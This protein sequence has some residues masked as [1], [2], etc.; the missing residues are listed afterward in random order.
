MDLGLFERAGKLYQQVLETQPLDLEAQKGRFL[1]LFYAGS[2]LDSLKFVRKRVASGT[3]KPSLLL[4]I[5]DDAIS[6]MPVEKRHQLL[7]ELLTDAIKGSREAQEDYLLSL[8][9]FKHYKEAI[10]WAEVNWRGP[11]DMPAYL[12]SMVA[13]AYFK[14][15]KVDKAKEYFL[16]ALDKNPASLRSQMG[17]AY[18]MAAEGN[19]HKALQLLDKLM[20]K[21][22]E[23]LEVRFAR[24]YAH[25]RLGQFL[26]AAY[27]YEQILEQDPGN[28][29]AQRLRLLALADL[30][31]PSFALRRAQDLFPEDQGL[32]ITLKH[33]VGAEHV[34][35]GEVERA[36]GILTPLMKIW[37]H[38]RSRFDYI[39]ALTQ[40]QE[41]HE[42]IEHYEA[43]RKKRQSI[44]P[45]VHEAAAGAYLYCEMP[46]KAL[47]LYETSLRLNPTSFHGRM[48]RFFA[49]QELRKWDE[50]W[51]TIDLLDSEV[52]PVIGLPHRPLPNW[53]KIDTTL[54]KGWLLAYE[55]RLAEAD[56]YFSS[57]LE[58]A[59]AHTGIRNGLAHIHL[60]RGWPRKS[61][62]E[63]QVIKTL[64]PDHFPAL[65]G[66]AM[67]LNTLAMKEEA[68]ALNQHLLSIEPRNKHL[69]ETAR[70]FKVE[71]MNEVRTWLSFTR[72]DDD[73]EQILATTELSS[74]LS[75]YTRL[76]L[77]S[78]WTHGSSKDL[79]E[80][81]WR[82]GIGVRHIFNSTIEAYQHFSFNRN[83]GNHLGSLTELTI[84]PDDYWKILL[85]F[86]SYSPDT[87]V[88][89]M[90]AGIRSRKAYA[91]ITYR[92][93]ELQSYYVSY[94]RRR[95]SDN[96]TREE[97]GA[98]L[99]RGLYTKRD[100]AVR[101]FVDLY[102]MDN[103]KENTPYY[104]PGK[105]WGLYTTLMAQQTLW[106]I[107]HRAFVH[108]LF[109]GAGWY[110]EQEHSGGIRAHLRY[111]QDHEFSDTHSLFWAV[112]VS[113]NIYDGDPVEGITWEVGWRL[114]F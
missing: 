67:A 80:N 46:E 42:A 29:I 97:F 2:Y 79:S 33:R 32:H 51:K 13:W 66:M 40:E 90:A 9:L 55:D 34:R 48:G 37:G 54:A 64:E 57:L 43:L 82:F 83:T 62:E 76:Y 14:T 68:R 60:W 75:L 99:E 49:L 15:G 108:R 23:S 5:R 84:T 107:Y 12:L 17:V 11:Q 101:L 72:E 70:R 81:L 52:P 39:V 73:S 56:E 71:Q 6:S 45:Y 113:R 3:G 89:A 85:S 16:V 59:P 110:D 105:S 50:A 102:R 95:L 112:Q 100:W 26:E 106:R 65:N 58:D 38:P 93:S 63:F 41:M 10:K 30:G 24:A 61:L 19:G 103:S 31:V 104:N 27:H 22:P 86:D 87:P 35:W 28:K 98:G 53:N 47:D 1:S 4:K 18:C 25:E 20:K 91:R 8:I 74:P 114:R 78:L 96:N 36:K 92:H 109:L 88:K 94:G 111:E 77:T 7:E 44:P 69:L 21:Y